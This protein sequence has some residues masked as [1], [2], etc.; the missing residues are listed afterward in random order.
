MNLDNCVK[1]TIPFFVIQNSG[2]FSFHMLK[3]AFMILKL[4]HER[5]MA[6]CIELKEIV[7]I[8]SL[9]V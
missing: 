9:R 7:I 2:L 8:I 1:V 5:Y 4:Y 6:F 3:L